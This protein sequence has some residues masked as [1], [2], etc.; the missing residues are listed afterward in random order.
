MPDQPEVLVVDDERSM[1]E[2]LSD[3][4]EAEGYA[5]Q[6]AENGQRAL[7]ILASS[8]PDVVVLDLMM[9]VLDGW[10]FMER[11]RDIAGVEIPIIGVSAVLTPPVADELRGGGVRACIPK[12]FDVG[13][14]VDSVSSAV[15]QP[16]VAQP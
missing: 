16:R 5:V 12:P 3:V 6:V 11:Y 13:D 7:E 8:R 9:P 14:L 4:L 2:L 10:A 1:R 15:Q